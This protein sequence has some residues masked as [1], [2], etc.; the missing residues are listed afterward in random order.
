MWRVSRVFAVTIAA[1]LTLPAA[2]EDLTIASKT[3]FGEVNG[4]QTAW[5]TPTRMKTAGGGSASI[6]DFRTGTMTFFDEA[7]KT[8]F[9]TSVEEMTAYAKRR[10][11]QAK[12]SG[13]VP[14][15]FGKLGAVTAKNTGRRRQIAGHS[16]DD[17]VL[18]MGNALVFEVCAAPR[19][20]VPPSYFDARKAAYA[21]MGPMGRHFEKM[22]D[23]MRKVRGYP[24]SLA[25]HVKM[26]ELKQETLNEATEVKTGAIPAAVFEVPA[27]YT[28]KKSPFAPG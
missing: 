8:Y 7:K 18:S 27:D 12:T 20:T 23:S 25:M 15:A 9:V 4:T 14:Q 28:K 21:G 10:E 13:F 17:W 5:V 3:R 11:E 22:F 2:A 24:L 6:F 16:C 26:E 19:L 1:A